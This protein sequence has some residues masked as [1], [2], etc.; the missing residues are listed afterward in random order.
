M[1]PRR[2]DTLASALRAIAGPEDSGPWIE[3]YRA[4]GGGYEGLQAI[5]EAALHASI[6]EPA[7]PCGLCGGYGGFNP[8]K[9]EAVPCMACGKASDG[10]VLVAVDDVVRPTIAR[11]GQ[12]RGLRL[13]EG[14]ADA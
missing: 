9:R 14:G 3:A 5:A 11:E 1:L 12:W 6:I 7:D 10:L 13:I 2:S 4:A 8:G